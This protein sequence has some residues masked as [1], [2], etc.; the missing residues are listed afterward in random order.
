MGRGGNRVAGGGD[1]RPGVRWVTRH[2]NSSSGVP[3]RGSD[4]GSRDLEMLEKDGGNKCGFREMGD[5]AGGGSG[6]LTVVDGHHSTSAIIVTEKLM[7]ASNAN[8]QETAPR[9]RGDQFTA[10]DPWAPAHAAMV[11]R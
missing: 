7:A 5:S 10:G 4:F 11:M 3:R 6:R 8:N 1:A 2:G 9:Q